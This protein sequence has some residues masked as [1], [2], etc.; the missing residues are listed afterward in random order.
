MDI[1]RLGFY[2]GDEL[3]ETPTCVFLLKKMKLNCSLFLLQL[4]IFIYYSLSFSELYKRAAG[5][6]CEVY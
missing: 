2:A 4:L 5:N 3:I 1:Y 6:N